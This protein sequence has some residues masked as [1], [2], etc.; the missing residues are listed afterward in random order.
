MAGPIAGVG[1]GGAASERLPVG[2]RG[3][4][5]PNLVDARVCAGTVSVGIRIGSAAS[6]GALLVDVG[7]DLDSSPF[8]DVGT[9]SI[10]GEQAAKS[11]ATPAAK[12]NTRSSATIFKP[13]TKGPINYNREVAGKGDAW[14]DLTVVL[15]IDPLYV[16]I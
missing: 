16:Y 11:S 2:W 3:R 1:V 13:Y 15:D 10:W 5:L 7:E 8:P 6:S 14:P 4:E 12:N 9:E